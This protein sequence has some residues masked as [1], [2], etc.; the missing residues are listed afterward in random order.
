MDERS[1]TFNIIQRSSWVIL[2]SKV[3]TDLLQTSDKTVLFMV[4]DK[5]ERQERHDLLERGRKKALFGGFCMFASNRSLQA[6]IPFL[7]LCKYYK[8]RGRL[9]PQGTYAKMALQLSNTRFHTSLILCRN[10][11]LRR[12]FFTQIKADLSGFSGSERLKGRSWTPD[13]WKAV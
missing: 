2:M 8:K 12:F 1:Y 3:S 5:S 11:K 6:D 9:F 10:L 13:V 7:G 4:L